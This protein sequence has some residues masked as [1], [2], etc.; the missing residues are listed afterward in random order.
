MARPLVED[1]FCGFP[2]LVIKSFFFSHFFLTKTHETLRY[3]N[4]ILIYDKKVNWF[5]ENPININWNFR[6]WTLIPQIRNKKIDNNK[7]IQSKKIYGFRILDDYEAEHYELHERRP[8]YR[9]FHIKPVQGRSQ[10]GGVHVLGT[11][12]PVLNQY[13]IQGRSQGRGLRDVQSTR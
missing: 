9:V 2:K 12:F 8:R 3:I 5:A 1:F 4:C 10:G 13:S 7:E 11:G 6:S